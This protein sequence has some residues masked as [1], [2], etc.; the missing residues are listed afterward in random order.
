MPD[1]VKPAL[2]VEAVVKALRKPG[3]WARCDDALIASS[4]V[5]TLVR[6]DT[7]FKAADLITALADE[8][9]ALRE[10]L[11]PFSEALS[12]Y[13]LGDDDLIEMTNK[14]RG[15]I[16]VMRAEHF[17]RARTLTNKGDNRG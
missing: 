7:P 14:L 6:D 1:P 5:E 13:D 8:N 12:R 9:K 15:R 10:G 17:I 2:P 11:R 16:A 3:T 4:A